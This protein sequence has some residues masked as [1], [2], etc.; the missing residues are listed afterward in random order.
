MNNTPSSAHPASLAITDFTYELPEDRIAQY[1]LAERDASKLLV[2]KDGEIRQQIF[3]DLPGLLQAND[4]LVFNDTRVIHAR[5]YF[6]KPTGAQIEILCLEP[7]DPAEVSESFARR[8]SCQWKALVGNAKRWKAGELLTKTIPSAAGSYRLSVEL[9]VKD[10]DACIVRFSWDRDV[11]FAEVLDDAGILPLPPYLNRDTEA[12]DEERYQT[13]YAQADGS[14]A[15]PTAGLHFTRN[16]FDA[17]REK[18]V[19]P[20]F[21]TLH[22]G[23]GTFKPVKA[24]TM[25]G[26]D[27]HKEKIHVSANAIEQMRRA[28]DHH[29][30][31]AVGTTSLRTMESIYWFGVRLLAGQEPNAFF[32]GQWE[33]YDLSGTSVAVSDAL[34]AVLDWMRKRGQPYLSGYTQLLIAPGY[35]IRLADALITNFHQPQSTLLLLV[36]AFIG[37]DWRRVYDYALQHDFRFLSFGDSSILFKKQGATQQDSASR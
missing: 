19:K 8:H 33:P 28:A 23:A 25:E 27:M 36:S 31:I 4:C 30:L 16:V 7:T 20:V 29:R 35:P 1:P 2:Y 21:V 26:H 37:E 11:A 9:C 3:K 10:T 6:E 34:E 5:I 17:L 14:V 24:S 18:T 32:V 15:A 22:V 12:E 13:V